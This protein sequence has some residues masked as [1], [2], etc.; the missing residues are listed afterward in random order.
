MHLPHRASLVCLCA[1]LGIIPFFFNQGVRAQVPLHNLLEINIAVGE[2]FAEYE[3]IVSGQG[4]RLVVTHPE[5][6]R[7][8]DEKE[9]KARAGDMNGEGWEGEEPEPWS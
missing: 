1:N 4:R 7:S 5:K 6:L 8:R 9:G 2:Q 3:N